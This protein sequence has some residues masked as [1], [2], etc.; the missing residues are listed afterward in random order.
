MEIEINSKKNNPLLAIP[1]AIGVSMNTYGEERDWTSPESNEG[2][3]FLEENGFEK[4]LRAGGEYSKK[5]NEEIKNI[6]KTEEYKQK[7][8]EEKEKI[9]KKL[10]AKIK[11]EIYKKY[12]FKK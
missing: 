12:N 4:T 6:V 8:N 3:K 7:P 9:I 10:R 11:E 1:T 2:K 5:V